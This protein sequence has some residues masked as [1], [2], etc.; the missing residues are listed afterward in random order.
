MYCVFTSGWTRLRS[1]QSAEEREK[2]RYVKGSGEW[3]TG[4]DSA[5]KTSAVNLIG[6]L[7]HMSLAVLFFLSPSKALRMNQNHGI[8]SRQRE[9]SCRPTVAAFKGER[10]KKPSE[11]CDGGASFLGKK[12]PESGAMLKSST[13][14]RFFQLSAHDWT[15][16]C[17]MK[18]QTQRRGM[19]FATLQRGRNHVM[20]HVSCCTNRKPRAFT[21]GL[22]EWMNL[23]SKLSQLL[24][25]LPTRPLLLTN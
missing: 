14:Y 10:K 23:A 22:S 6:S 18:R 21:T 17:P 7:H 9:T 2:G 11:C 24:R 19:R 5:A 15:S 1:D 13:V 12:L 4:S 8:I 3:D 20:H 16:P 25:R